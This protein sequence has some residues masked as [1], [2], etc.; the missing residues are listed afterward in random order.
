MLK[1][2]DFEILRGVKANSRAQI[3]L[4]RQP[5][6]VATLLDESAFACDH[7]II[8]RRTVFLEDRIHDWDWTDGWFRYYSRVD[9]E[10]D[11]LIV[12]AC[13]DV[14][15]APRFDPMTG[16]ALIQNTAS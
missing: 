2:T 1:A 14:Q 4:A 3:P 15:P 16:K 9:E 8:H 11:V 13:E 6:R 7:L 5:A 10:A 12:Y